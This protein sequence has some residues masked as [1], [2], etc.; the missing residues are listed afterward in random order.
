[1]S[2][3]KKFIRLHVEPGRIDGAGV[4]AAAPLSRQVARRETAVIVKGAQTYREFRKTFG[5]LA[6]EG[7][8]RAYLDTIDRAITAK[9]S[10]TSGWASL[11]EAADFIRE[12]E[13]FW[14][15]LGFATFDAYWR[16]RVGDYFSDWRAL[17]AAYNYAVL[18]CPELFNVSFEE[19][20]Q[21]AQLTNRL[22]QIEPLAELGANQ[23]VKRTHTGHYPTE[24]DAVNRV[25][26]AAQWENLGSNSIQY[27]VAK[28]RRDKPEIYGQMLDGKFFKKTQTG[29][30][31]IDLKAAEAAAGMN[32]P[33]AR[34]KKELMSRAKQLVT[35]VKNQLKENNTSQRVFIDEL[36]NI[37]WVIK[38][39]KARGWERR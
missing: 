17:E 29:V 3:N 5:E 38:A 25:V 13:G 32:E 12:H 34:P 33:K 18:A 15:E 6:E 26:Q 14:K 27:R 11:Y 19:A 9:T 28:I 10:D 8:R 20:S 35:S 39:L 1:M 37:P 16:D 21:K 22:R 7:A 31:M 30:V 2:P 24:A 23:H 36:L 4:V